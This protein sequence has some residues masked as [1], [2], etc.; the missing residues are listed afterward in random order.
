MTLETKA[1]ML[2]HAR[3]IW[4]ESG[5]CNIAVIGGDLTEGCPEHAPYSLIFM[6]GSVADIPD[7]FLA[8]LSLHGR[9]ITVWRP[10][11]AKTGTAIMI[12]RVGDE[13]YSTR[14]LFDAATPY[15]PG[16]EPRPEFSF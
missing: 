13:Q 4:A 7:I 15:I 3:R 5:Y 2:D 12:E 8:Q 1:G 16:F 14:K 9:L 11:G 6:N 10:G